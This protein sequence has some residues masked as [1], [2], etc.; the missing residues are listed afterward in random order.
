LVTWYVRL[1]CRGR[2]LASALFCVLFQ[3][4]GRGREKGACSANAFPMALKIGE[5]SM[6]SRKPYRRFATGSMTWRGTVSREPSTAL[7]I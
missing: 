2:S 1:A 4:L 7:G 6:E 3:V 5:V